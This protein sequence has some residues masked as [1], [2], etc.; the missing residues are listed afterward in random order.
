[1]WTAEPKL[2]DRKRAGMVGVLILGFL[3]LLLYLANKQ[4]WRP[5]K[6]RKD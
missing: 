4:L 2:N 5:I 6:Y 3:T 1:M